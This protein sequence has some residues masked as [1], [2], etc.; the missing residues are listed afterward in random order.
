MYSPELAPELLE[1]SKKIFRRNLEKFRAYSPYINSNIFL[2]SGRI[3]IDHYKCPQTYACTLQNWRQNYWNSQKKI[4]VETWKNF[5]RTVLIRSEVCRV[6]KDGS[7]WTII[8]F[9]KTTHVLSR[10]GARTTGTLKKN[11]SSELGKISSVQSLYKFKYL[12]N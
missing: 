1:L 5:E 11:F 8:I 10:T 6:G 2:I 7:L 12:F 9:F 4:F 3:V